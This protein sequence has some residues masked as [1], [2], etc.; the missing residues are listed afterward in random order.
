MQRTLYPVRLE[1]RVLNDDDDDGYRDAEGDGAGEGD[2]K[3]P[4]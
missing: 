4:L 3:K 1:F 2:G